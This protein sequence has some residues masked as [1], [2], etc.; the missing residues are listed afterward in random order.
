MYI[1]A[2]H[3]KGMH[4]NIALKYISLSEDYKINFYFFRSREIPKLLPE[5][6]PLVESMSWV[7]AVNYNLSNRL[8]GDVQV[9]G[10]WQLAA[11]HFLKITDDTLEL[12]LNL[13]SRRRIPCRNVWSESRPG[14]QHHRPQ[15]IE[16]LQLPRKY[17]L[18]CAILMSESMLSFH[19]E[20]WEVIVLRKHNHNTM[21]TYVRHE[22]WCG[23]SGMDLLL[24]SRT[25]SS[26][27]CTHENVNVYINPWDLQLISSP[28]AYVDSVNKISFFEFNTVVIIWINTITQLSVHMDF[29]TILISQIYDILAWGD[30]MLTH[31][32]EITLVS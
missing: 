1:C 25:N 22:M 12:I 24:K 10:W 13:D 6:E 30:A 15:L 8:I 20:F 19:L 7:A 21:V 3:C 4:I 27:I 31:S 16:L 28:L 29:N 17:I 9:Q 23:S 14:R 2:Y 11:D 26:V 18:C 32:V 5:R